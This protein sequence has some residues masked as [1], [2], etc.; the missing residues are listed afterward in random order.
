MK[1]IACLNLKMNITTKNLLICQRGLTV[2]QKECNQCVKKSLYNSD[3]NIGLNTS[4]LDLFSKY[5]LKN[6]QKS[7]SINRSLCPESAHI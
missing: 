3:Y 2:W 4:A 1:D 7:K 6:G 5:R